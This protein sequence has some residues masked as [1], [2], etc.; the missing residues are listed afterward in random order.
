[1]FLT[2]GAGLGCEGSVGQPAGPRGPASGAEGASAGG[3]GASGVQ[4]GSGS[5]DFATGRVDPLLCK[6]DQ[7]KPGSMP[8]LVRL[9]HRQYDYAVKDLLGV[10][11]AA[12]T[13]F[14]DD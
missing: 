4:S 13:E 2:L 3:L 7:P 1:M 9:T 10:D 8:G 14:V 12:S 6:S 11:A 5:G